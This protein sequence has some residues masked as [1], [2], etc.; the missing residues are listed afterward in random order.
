MSK[1]S[2]FVRPLLEFLFPAAD[3]ITLQI[4]HGYIRKSAH[5]TEY[6]VLGFLAARAFF[7]SARPFLKKYWWLVALITV[8]GV[9]ATDEF[10]QSFNPARTGTAWDVGIDLLG[11]AAGTAFWMLLSRFRGRITPSRSSTRS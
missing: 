1:T 9:A 10:N 7:T 11:G 8:L 6:A 3:E 4:Y 2:L 5:V